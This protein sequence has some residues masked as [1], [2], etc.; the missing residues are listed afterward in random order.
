ML[1]RTFFFLTNN[2]IF[3]K[4]LISL[5]LDALFIAKFGIYKRMK[6]D[7][8]LSPQEMA[9]FSKKEAV[10]E[11]IDKTHN[12]LKDVVKNNLTPGDAILDIGC[13]AGAYLKEFEEDYDCTGIDL[14]SEMI[15]AGKKYMPK[16]NLLL[17]DFTTHSFNKKF[18][19]IYSVSVLEFIAPSKLKLFFEKVA[20]LL[21]NNG[22]LFLHYPHAL[23]SIDLYFPDLYYIEYSPE[24]IESIAT[25]KF[26]IQ[27]HHHGW[28]NRTVSNY[29]L[30][31]YQPGIRT[32]KNG[33]LLIAKLK[34]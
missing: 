1:G 29:D 15:N 32:F 12:D 27:S 5:K 21:Q 10:Q 8:T 2:I 20:S 30:Y 26:T 11:A 4:I 17:D 31:P 6:L 19:L 3:N 23:K 16:A 24:L 13:G 34:S 25:N 33:Y 9:G 18:N 28:D 14:N 7:T 22:M